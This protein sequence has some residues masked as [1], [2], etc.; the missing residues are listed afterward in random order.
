VQTFIK[1]KL[2]S[3]PINSPA[4]NYRRTNEDTAV[5]SYVEY[6]EKR[7]ITLIV[8]KCG[9]FIDPSIPWLA[10]TPDSV[11]EIGQDTRCLEVKCPFVCA[12]KSIAVVSLVFLFEKQ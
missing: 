5:R 7:G 8:H 11:V 12:K 9:L 2:A 3:K 6:Q 10:A 1:N 4:I